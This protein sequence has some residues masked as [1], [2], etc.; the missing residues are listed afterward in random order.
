MNNIQREIHIFQEGDQNEEIVKEEF[1]NLSLSDNFE[2]Y[3]LGLQKFKIY[4]DLTYPNLE[5]PIA[6]IIK[7]QLIPK[8]LFH[9]ENSFYRNQA[10]VLYQINFIQEALKKYHFENSFIE[11]GLMY[12]LI[13]LISLKNKIYDLE[14]I[15]LF[16]LLLH[17]SNN[18][19]KHN[20]QVQIIVFIGTQKVMQMIEY[21]SHQATKIKQIA[22]LCNIN[23]QYFF[24]E[25]KIFIEQLCQ[26]ILNESNQSGQFITAIE[27]ISDIIGYE[28][29]KQLL[30]ENKV[31]QPIIDAIPNWIDQYR[32]V[33]D[34]ILKICLEFILYNKISRQLVVTYG[35]LKYLKLL[36]K[37]QFYGIKY[38]SLKIVENLCYEKYMVERLY[39]NSVVRTILEQFLQNSRNYEFISTLV[40]LLEYGSL[41]FFKYCLD[42]A[43]EFILEFLKTFLSFPEPKVCRSQM[44]LIKVFQNQ[45]LFYDEIQQYLIE[46]QEIIKQKMKFQQFNDKQFF[47]FYQINQKFE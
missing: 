38:Y 21:Q 15:R 19:Y 36:I 5:E 2:E 8:M 47:D 35:L 13:R 25:K 6:Q 4:L 30:L 11:N 16:I 46:N 41:M 29:I 14:I 10:D 28:N 1:I 27:L 18:K 40:R 37:S 33:L 12:I 34:S 3:Q 32:S 45:G 17:S 43:Q 20:I 22:L 23:D 26:I 7:K 39:I 42:I 24:N 9:L 31:L 44:A